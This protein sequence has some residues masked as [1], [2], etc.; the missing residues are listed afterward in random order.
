MRGA[1]DAG[2]RG[3]VCARSAG[4]V[5]YARGALAACTLGA[6]ITAALA[7]GCGVAAADL[8]IVTRTGAGPNAHLTLLVNEEGGVTC[9]GRLA[10]HK[11]SDPQIDKAREIQEE[12][13]KPSAEHLTLAP[14]AGSVLSYYVRDEKGSVRFADNS[15]GQPA[16]LHKLQ[17]FVLQ[18]AQEICHLPQ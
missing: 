7:S 3:R 9:N 18:S 1:P 2:A 4:R 8:F 14:R 12:L 11:L 6:L 16:A 10:A 15:A 17:L 5:A 13:E